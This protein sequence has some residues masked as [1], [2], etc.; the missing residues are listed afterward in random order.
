MN[1]VMAENG[2]MIDASQIAEVAEGSLRT[3]ET[4][5]LLLG[6]LGNELGQ[7]RRWHAERHRRPTPAH[8]A[9]AARRHG[10]GS[11]ARTD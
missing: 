4:G 7:A 8:G 3:G 9:G 11:L 10:H 2:A 6:A 1:Y 5:Y